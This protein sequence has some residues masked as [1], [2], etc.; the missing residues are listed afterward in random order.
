MSNYWHIQS[1][2][3]TC[4]E[5]ITVLALILTKYLLHSSFLFWIQIV[6]VALKEKTL[7]YDKIKLKYM[8][9]KHFKMRGGLAKS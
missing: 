7:F 2:V 8:E 9:S 6:C 4:R 1:V 5:I 3:N